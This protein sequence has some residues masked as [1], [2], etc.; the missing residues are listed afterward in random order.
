MRTLFLL[1]FLLISF[2]HVFPQSRDVIMPPPPSEIHNIADQDKGFWCA[3]DVNGGS[4]LMVNRKNVAMAGASFA[5]GYRFC[6]YLK[7]GV[8]LGVL[9]YPNN[10]DV[11]RSNSY[12][13]MPLFFNV[14]GNLL[15]EGIRRTVPFWSVNIGSTIPDGFFITPSVGLRIGE[16][17]NAFI[18]SIGYTF[19][20]L[21]TRPGLAEYYSGAFVKLGY[22]F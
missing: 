3:I 16:K 8:G 5:G 9:F 17:R 22:E 14:R 10:S 1:F 20:H 18:V 7:V 15:S 2:L 4:T 11:R 21:K 6:Q 19:R 13:A 12:V